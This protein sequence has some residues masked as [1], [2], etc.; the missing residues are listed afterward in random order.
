MIKV[1]LTG[2]A[3]PY[4]AFGEF[5]N[6][7]HEYLRIMDGEVMRELPVDRIV[8]IWHV[9]PAMTQEPAQKRFSPQLLKPEAASQQPKIDPFQTEGDDVPELPPGIPSSYR[10]RQQYQ[11][12]ENIQ[13]LLSSGFRS[14]Q[15][16]AVD[17]GT[18]RLAVVITGSVQ[19]SF[20]IEVPG[21]V[22]V[23]SVYTPT[24]AKEIALNP[25]IKQ[26][27]DQGII[28]TGVPSVVG[29][30]VLIDT[31]HLADRMKQAGEG[32][33]LAS[34]TMEAVGR[35]QKPQKRDESLFA[36]LEQ[37]FERSPFD[38]P[39]RLDD[40]EDNE[41]NGYDANSGSEEAAGERSAESG[42]PEL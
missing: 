33:G 27:M 29:E 20:D 7:D 9:E 24:L 28:F 12:L 40:V 23:P 2:F 36:G 14:R 18:K 13:D 4:I 26:I 25:R 42:L 5:L 22:F 15:S 38:G 21:N 31:A 37:P 6:R 11:S 39:V 3:K 19:D 1:F 30:S 17:T 41:G 10:P 32:L 35:L 8:D 16:E 34:R